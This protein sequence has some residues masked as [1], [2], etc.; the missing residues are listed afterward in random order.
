MCWIGRDASIDF[1]PV[2]CGDEILQLLAFELAA[3]GDF[4]G[5]GI[6]LIVVNPD[7]VV[8]VRTC[9]QAGHPAKGD[10]FTLGYVF[11]NAGVFGKTGE[12]TICRRITVA[13]VNDDQ[14]SVLSS[15]A[16]ECNFAA[17][18]RHHGRTLRHGEINAFVHPRVAKDRMQPRAE[19]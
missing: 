6:D 3:G 4:Y 12:M 16:F 7:L 2:A 8:K 10:D 13:V 5:R 18:G 1:N 9:G 11:A 14:V 17:A 19:S 15:P